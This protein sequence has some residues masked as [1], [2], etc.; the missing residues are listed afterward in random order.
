MKMFGY[1][2]NDA[3][4]ETN[5]MM[6]LARSGAVM[7][8]GFCLFMTGF[9]RQVLSE[10]DAWSRRSTSGIA[11]TLQVE[12]IEPQAPRVDALLRPRRGNIAHNY[13]EGNIVE[14]ASEDDDDG[15]IGIATVD[16]ASDS[17]L[18]VEARGSESDAT[19]EH[20][21]HLDSAPSSAS[22]PAHDGI[23]RIVRS[24]E[25]SLQHSEEGNDFHFAL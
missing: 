13:E 21:L 7:S 2:R 25:L 9:Q 19:N 4:G 5:Q 1:A 8:I 14:V 15:E 22:S 3:N 6:M 12:Y 17:M 20:L 18:I 11:I 24:S 16:E 23:G 10:F